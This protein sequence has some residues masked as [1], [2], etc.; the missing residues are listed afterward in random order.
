MSVVGLTTT[1]SRDELPADACTTSLAGI[2][3]GRID[4]TNRGP[5]FL[6]LLVLDQEMQN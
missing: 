4:R 2:H 6:E 3:I 1:H 5:H